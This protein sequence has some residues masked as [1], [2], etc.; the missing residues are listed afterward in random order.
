MTVNKL[1]DHKMY[2]AIKKFTFQQMVSFL[3]TIY[4]EG[5]KTAVKEVNQ[6]I[7]VI[8]ENK[9][10]KEIRELIRKEYGIGK[11]RYTRADMEKKILDIVAACTSKAEISD[12][13]VKLKKN[14]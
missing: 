13:D 8:D 9:L 12:V 11:K 4:T 1:I 10:E 6:T 5:Y 3:T 14:T 2:Q 7:N